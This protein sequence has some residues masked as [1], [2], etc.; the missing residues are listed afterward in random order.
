M[1]QNPQLVDDE[2]EKE[3]E[4]NGMCGPYLDPDSDKPTGRRKRD[5][6]GNFAIGWI[7]NN[8]K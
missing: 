5:H 4:P 8:V 2:R 7:F 3:G 6:E 1:T